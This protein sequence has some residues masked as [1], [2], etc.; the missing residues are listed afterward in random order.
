[1]CIRDEKIVDDLRDVVDDGDELVVH[2]VQDAHHGVTGVEKGIDDIEEI[3]GDEDGGKKGGD[4]RADGEQEHGLG[5]H[6]VSP[7]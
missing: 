6:F 3:T 2:I 7:R 5:R 4:D 1:M